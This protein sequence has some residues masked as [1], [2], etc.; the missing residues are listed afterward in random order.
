MA[1]VADLKNFWSGNTREAGRWRIGCPIFGAAMDRTLRFDRFDRV[2]HLVPAKQVVNRALQSVATIDVR[3]IIPAITIVAP[4]VIR[5]IVACDCC[6]SCYYLSSRM[7]R[8]CCIGDICRRRNNRYCSGVDR[9]A[10]AENLGLAGS[11]NLAYLA[12][13][14]GRALG[15]WPQS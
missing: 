7:D 11:D 3:A 4:I 1:V 12:I 6:S 9:A 14:A 2:V 5:I 13:R 8:Y 10:H 15:R